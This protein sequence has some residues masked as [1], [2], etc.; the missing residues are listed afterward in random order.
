[1]SLLSNVAL[2]FLGQ[3]QV[4]KHEL[5][6]LLAH[7]LHIVLFL[8][9]NAF[10][11]VIAREQLY[12]QAD[13]REPKHH[14]KE[15]SQQPDWSSRIVHFLE[16]L[17]LVVSALLTLLPAIHVFVLRLFLSDEVL[18]CIIALSLAVE[19]ASALLVHPTEVFLKHMSGAFILVIG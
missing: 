2:L 17:V 6:L 10:A 3:L 1:M 5:G 13:Y 9:A 8:C 4:L 15:D 18:E 16:L 7:H 12:G 11:A 19:A 14:P